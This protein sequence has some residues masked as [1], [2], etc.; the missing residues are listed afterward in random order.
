MTMASRPAVGDK[1]PDLELEGTGEKTYRLSDYA[2]RPIEP[3]HS[4]VPRT[5]LPF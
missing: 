4:G 2:G 3:G 5:N 1:A